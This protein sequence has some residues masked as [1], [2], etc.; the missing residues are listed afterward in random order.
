MDYLR[1]EIE[2]KVIIPRPLQLAVGIQGLVAFLPYPDPIISVPAK[3]DRDRRLA[4]FLVIKHNQRPL[5]L[6]VDCEFAFD[7][8]A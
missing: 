6:G 1:E 7:T 8:A 5:R 3:I 2:R 4:Y